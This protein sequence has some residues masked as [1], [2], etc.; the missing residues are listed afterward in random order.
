MPTWTWGL[1]GALGLCTVA[2]LWWALGSG[3]P[4]AWAIFFSLASMDIS[5][6]SWAAHRRKQRRTRE[7]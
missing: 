6:S 4:A 1:L 5:V 3:E 7:R 2:A